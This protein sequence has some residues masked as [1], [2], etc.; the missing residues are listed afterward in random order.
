MVNAEHTNYH[1]MDAAEVCALLGV[2]PSDGLSIK[3]V[4]RRQLRDG[5][6][7]LPSAPQRTLFGI[8][9][10]Q[11]ASPMMAVIVGAAGASFAIGHMADGIFISS[12][13]V[14]NIVLGAI[15]EA[16]AERAIVLLQKSLTF[17]ATVRR[18]GVR[19][20]IDSSDVVVGDIAM[21][22]PGDRVPADGRIVTAQHA[23]VSEAMLTG[24]SRPVEKHA[25]PI[26]AAVGVADRT[27]M[28]Y[29]GTVVE[30]GTIEFVV[31]AIGKA[32]QMG[33]IATL[34]AAQRQR[35]SPLQHALA[36]LSR[37]ITGFVLLAVGAFVA[38]G[39]MQGLPL[40]DV[41]LAAVALVVSTI[42]EGLLP[43]VT[44]VLALGMRRLAQDK[45]LVR[46][47]SAVETMGAISVICLDK[48]G[49]LTTGEMRVSH[50]LSAQ[51]LLADG[52][53]VDDNA[54]DHATLLR[55]GMLVNDATVEN[56]EATTNAW[57]LSGRPTDRALLLAGLQS[58]MRREA[59]LAQRTVEE[60]LLFNSARKYAA[61]LYRLS[62]GERE[63]LVL[64]APEHVVARCTQYGSAT[65]HRILS[66]AQRE[67]ILSR[68]QQLATEGYRLLACA[69]RTDA[70]AMSVEDLTFVGLI[71]LKDPVRP[72]VPDALVTAQRAGVRPL[73]IT[74]DH[75]NTAAAVL[76]DVGMG[77]AREHVYEGRDIERL[78]DAQ[79]QNIVPHAQ[80]FARVSPE[81]KIRIVRALMARD[82]VVAMVG[83]GVNDAPAL[84]AADVGIAIGSGTDLAKT[85][86]DVVLLDDS[87]ATIV[88]AIRQGRQVFLNVKRILFFLLVDDLT[89]LVI[90][91]VALLCSVPLPLLPAHILWINLVVDGF[92][93]MALTASHGGRHL[94]RHKPRRLRAA[95]LSRSLMAFAFIVF[96]ASAAFALALFFGALAMGMPIEMVRTALFA[97]ISIDSLLFAY[98][99]H[100]FD[101]PIFSREVFANMYLNGAIGISIIAI[102]AG[103]YVPALQG[104]LA[105]VALPLSTWGVILGCAAVE[106]ALLEV[107]KRFLVRA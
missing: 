107:A 70:A 55:I 91:F 46:R 45:A 47:L 13:I 2:H 8:I 102:L 49:T 59:L 32:T 105:T 62:S 97:F 26:D 87:F 67:A 27:N 1:A 10:Q 16:K 44:V 5:K 92:P 54:Q 68:I 33:H 98:I 29:A 57:R 80:L 100:T 63:L 14:L 48:T 83:D 42:P 12:V 21:L 65:H 82:A 77:V 94:M 35:L 106:L 90:F 17:R 30:D 41:A 74:G 71:A 19:H 75:R 20:T 61:R 72:E 40:R 103:I 96:S 38:L 81:H 37:W 36:Q 66:S 18:Q 93:G 79:L 4:Q 84:K 23:V 89:E 43:A 22:M 85:V 9:V 7:I 51:E 53:A 24:E 28:V 58:G 95:L 86:A 31:T 69:L 6:N 73:V 3:D 11:L 60:Q 56:P 101:R 64:G 99:I 78:D 50:V 88:R 52:S 25:E 39:S 15:Q 76:A 104:I 34:L